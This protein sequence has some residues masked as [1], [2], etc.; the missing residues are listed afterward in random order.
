MGGRTWLLSK[1]SGQ[2]CEG[3]LDFSDWV[4]C[5]DWATAVRGKGKGEIDVEDEVVGLGGKGEERHREG[6]ERWE[7]DN[8]CRPADTRLITK[9][10]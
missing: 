2:A 9:L 10:F 7:Q 3:H 1:S 5:C 4:S 6:G 8:C